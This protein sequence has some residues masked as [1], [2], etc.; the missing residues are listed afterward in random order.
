MANYI[1]Y[2]PISNIFRFFI[3]LPNTHNYSRRIPVFNCTIL[4]GTV[5][6]ESA[7]NFVFR[8]NHRKIFR[9]YNRIN[10]RQN[11]RLVKIQ[12]CYFEV[13]YLHK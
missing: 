9:R 10:L 7:Q 3:I 5:Y 11:W 2:F 13:T 12:E 4:V 6:R 8:K 1:I